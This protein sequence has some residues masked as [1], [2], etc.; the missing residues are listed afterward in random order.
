MKVK[1]ILIFVLMILIIFLVGCTAKTDITKTISKNLTAKDLIPTKEAI[2]ATTELNCTSEIYNTS[3]FSP[4]AENTF[5]N[6]NINDSEFYLEIKKFS[7]QNDLNGSYQYNSAHL[8]GSKGF[9][10]HT[11]YGDQSKLHV[12]AGD[13]YGA[14][15]DPKGVSFYHLWF[16]K[17]LYLIHITSKGVESDRAYIENIGKKILNKYDG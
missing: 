11:I 15:F 17:D 1:N 9:L 12:N 10:N 8:F 16:T 7:N 6:F 4:L 2:G 13:D 3:E 14:E 5:C